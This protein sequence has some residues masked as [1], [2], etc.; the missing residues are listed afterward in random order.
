MGTF[1][2]NGDISATGTISASS[3]LGHASSATTARFL[4]SH[5]TRND[6]IEPNQMKANEAV[7]FDFKAASTIGL[8]DAPYSG[9][10]SYR[11]YSS[12]SDWSGGPAHQLAFN[13]AGLYWRQSS[14][15]SWLSWNKLIHSGNYT[16]YTVTKTGSGASGTWGI[17]ITGNAA[18]AS[19]ASWASGASYAQRVAGTYT[20]NGGAQGPS[21]IGRGNVKF[22]MMNQFPNA[23]ETNYMDCI[24]MNTYSGGD[25]PRATAFGVERYS[26]RA[27]I[28]E[29]PDTSSTWAQVYEVIST[30]NIASQSVNYATSA[31]NADTVDGW[32]ADGFL[33]KHGWWN[34]SG[35]YSVDNLTSGIVFAYTNHG[36]PASWGH[37]IAFTSGGSDA[38]VCQLHATG[39]N[40]LFMRNKSSDYGQKGWTE[41]LTDSNYSQWCLPL[42]GGAMS[43]NIIIGSNYITGETGSTEAKCHG[44]QLGYP[45]HDYWT[46][47]EWGGLYHFYKYQVSGSTVTVNTLCGSIN[48]YGWVQGP[49]GYGSTFP[50]SPAVG[51]VFYKT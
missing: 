36:A 3:F 46:F 24:L 21:Y 15:N 13:N 44:L 7:Q 14:G 29:G 32:H 18:T 27:W 2:V 8:T 22:N 34:S 49:G 6:S 19:S 23:S 11:P 25:V 30:R 17:S 9:V 40:R 26:G 12:D 20:G 35:S 43:G 45:N 41:F 5:D 51:Q 42:S 38:Y 1:K 48:E 39:T 47:S 10:M 50:S 16:D 37:T 31:G 4:S 28:A 33:Q